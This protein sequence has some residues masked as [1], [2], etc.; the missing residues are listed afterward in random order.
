MSTGLMNIV[1]FV[2][3]K[4]AYNDLTWHSNFTLSR[5]P[6]QYIILNARLTRISKPL[7]QQTQLKLDS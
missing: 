4:H 6:G 1:W 7:Q 5:V 3:A 2:S